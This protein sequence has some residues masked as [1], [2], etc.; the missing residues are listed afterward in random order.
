MK[1]E[2]FTT[3]IDN[4]GFV[5]PSRREDIMR[6]YAKVKVLEAANEAAQSSSS[7]KNNA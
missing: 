6:G 2:R 4:R 7:T 1:M 3:F 5:K